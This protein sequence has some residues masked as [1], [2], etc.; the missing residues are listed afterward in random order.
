MSVSWSMWFLPGK[1]GFV[2]VSSPRMQ[3]TAQTSEGLPYLSVSSSSG[4]RYQRVAT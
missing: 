1:S 3:P 4:E 2:S